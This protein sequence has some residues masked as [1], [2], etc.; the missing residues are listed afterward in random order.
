MRMSI[1][2]GS[3]SYLGKVEAISPDSVQQTA[4]SYTLDR[5]TIMYS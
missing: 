3:E 1:L 2:L 4:I 5:L